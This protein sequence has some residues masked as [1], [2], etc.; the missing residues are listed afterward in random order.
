MAV[1][2]HCV[3][4]LLTNMVSLGLALRLK[5]ILG[6]SLKKV[7]L[8]QALKISKTRPAYLS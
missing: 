2:E 8:N 7:L 5:F 3:N 4:C 6:Q 1:K